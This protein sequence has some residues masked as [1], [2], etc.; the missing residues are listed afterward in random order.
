MKKSEKA[1][2]INNA[3]C[4]GMNQ[5][6]P[7][8]IFFALLL[9][10]SQFKSNL[11][12][13]AIVATS[14]EQNPVCNSKTANILNVTFVGAFLIGLFNETGFSFASVFHC[15]VDDLVRWF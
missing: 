15:F 9:A 7:Q 10:I 11:T 2:H 4:K 14:S 1:F 12:L 3:S 13:I 8:N 6:L 5:T